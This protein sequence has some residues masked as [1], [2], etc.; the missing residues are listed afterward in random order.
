MKLVAPLKLDSN[1]GCTG[2]KTA[3]EPVRVSCIRAEFRDPAPS[4]Q[5]LP[6]GV[7][8]L[9]HLFDVP[10]ETRLDLSA[11]SLLFRGRLGLALSL[12]DPRAAYVDRYELN[13]Q[14]HE[15]S[16][17]L[18][19]TL[20]ATSSD[21][22][23]TRLNQRSIEGERVAMKGKIAVRLL[24]QRRLG[25]DPIVCDSARADVE[26]I[27]SATALH[28]HPSIEEYGIASLGWSLSAQTSGGTWVGVARAQGHC[29]SV[30]EVARRV[31]Q[32]RSAA[33]LVRLAVPRRDLAFRIA[34]A[35]LGRLLVV[36]PHF[37]WEN[38][39]LRDAPGSRRLVR[40][41]VTNGVAF[42]NEVWNKVGVFIGSRPAFDH[43]TTDEQNP[44]NS[45]RY[46]GND[47]SIDYD[48][49][50]WMNTIVG[51]NLAVT[52]VFY[53][54]SY[55][56]RGNP[57]DPETGK[58]PGTTLPFGLGGDG[59][60]AVGAYIVTS[61]E[62]ENFSEGARTAKYHLA[63]E[64]G[65]V[66]GLLH[67]VA[68]RIAECFSPLR[69]NPDMILNGS[70][71][72]SPNTVSCPESIDAVREQNSVWNGLYATKNSRMVYFYVPFA[73]DFCDP[74]TAEG[75]DCPGRLTDVRRRTLCPNPEDPSEEIEDPSEE[76]SGCA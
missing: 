74:R 21:G 6:G 25:L 72:G 56:N 57:F 9:R 7:L 30:S 67:P 60:G 31:T 3:A 42:A 73:P 35:R 58:T 61:Q 64:I 18:Y 12:D 41:L 69:E 10:I 53:F 52:H 51:A 55:W 4:R 11:G 5:T 17:R 37:I 66:L 27:V 49:K 14:I 23:A 47:E 2:C 76:R 59:S 29:D 44:P 36:Q 75:A 33:A 28:E 20:S 26:V 1:C 39:G 46:R 48:H 19:G 34:L 54:G 8:A 62:Y 16:G 13:G 15:A 40:H 71:N 22:P 24:I 45:T 32:S 50:E 68:P 65:H 43:A 38:A 63:H 70:V